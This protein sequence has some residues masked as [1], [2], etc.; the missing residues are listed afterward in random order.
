[1]GAPPYTEELGSWFAAQHAMQSQTT[2]IDKFVGPE[3][4]HELGCR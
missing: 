3:A 1:M 4:L 2:H